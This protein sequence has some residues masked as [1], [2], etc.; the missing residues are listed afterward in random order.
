MA[1]HRALFILTEVN[2]YTK[3]A[4]DG[5]TSEQQTGFYLPEIAHPH[6]ILTHHG[7][8]VDFATPHGKPAPVDE[9]SVK[10]YTDDQSKEFH[11]KYIV[12]GY[13]S[14]VKPVAEH[15]IQDYGGSKRTVFVALIL[16]FLTFETDIAFFP[17]GHGP[18]FDLATD[19]TV[20]AWVAKFYEVR[21]GVV[22]A[23]CHGP[24]GLIPVKLSNNK[25]LVEGKTISCFTDNEESA[26]GL[27]ASVPFPLETRLRQLG[28]Q[29]TAVDLWK[30]IAV[31]SERVVTGQNPASGAP[32]GEALIAAAKIAFNK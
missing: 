4:A 25:P 13:I 32:V 7:Y 31:T 27:S 23:V 5:S 18:M 28:A 9:G 16:A 24:A 22:G 15:N 17:G 21:K 6:H 10:D 2:K 1:T 29:T 8:K 3:K 11:A 12:D 14:N 20:G 19:A 30:P 26:A